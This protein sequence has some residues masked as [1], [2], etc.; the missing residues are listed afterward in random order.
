MNRFVW[1]SYEA[2]LWM[3]DMC[4]VPAKADVIIPDVVTGSVVVH[5][6]MVFAHPVL[7]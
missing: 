3:V 6:H 5:F 2:K 4:V 1:T 7:Q